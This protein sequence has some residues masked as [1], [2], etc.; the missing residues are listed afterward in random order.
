MGVGPW[1]LMGLGLF[2]VRN[3]GPGKALECSGVLWSMAH[4][5]VQQW[6]VLVVSHPGVP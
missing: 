3:K 5:C 2:P 4:R 1:G 6:D